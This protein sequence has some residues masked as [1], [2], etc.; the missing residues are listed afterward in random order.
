MQAAVGYY[1]G[2]IHSMIDEKPKVPTMLHFGELDAHIPMD[3][4][5]E[6]A[7]AHPDV[8]VH[9]YNANHGFHCDQRADY[10]EASAKQAWART[11]EFF[12]EHL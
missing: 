1:G 3:N 9:T 6:V 12:G 10:D 11:L 5:N 7:A 8:T 2:G 4:V